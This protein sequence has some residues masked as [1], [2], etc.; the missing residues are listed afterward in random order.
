MIEIM[1]T[2]LVAAALGGLIGGLLG[3]FAGT[4]M[5]RHHH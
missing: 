5:V 4:W 3:A 2:I 1:S